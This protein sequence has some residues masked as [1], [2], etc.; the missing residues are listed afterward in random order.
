MENTHK[1]HE[2][3]THALGISRAPNQ[4]G[5][6]ALAQAFQPQNLIKRGQNIW[7][8]GDQPGGLYYNREGVFVE[9]DAQGD[10]TSIIRLVLPDQL[11][12][13]EDAYFYHQPATTRLRCLTPGA[14]WYLRPDDYRAVLEM[15]GLGYE[16]INVL[17]LKVL[18]EYRARTAQLL[19]WSPQFR[20]EQALRQ[21]PSLLS[22]LTRDEL[23]HFLL[24]SRSSLH[25]ILT[26][27][28]GRG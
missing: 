4:S 24:L 9:E 28:Y 5:L 20:L 8:P 6:L 10:G 21:Y 23:A 7:S 3:L 14:T 2:K 17:S 11:F 18:G 12:F 27:T 26:K 15:H 13:S 25:R 19:Q 1:I 16:L 22:S